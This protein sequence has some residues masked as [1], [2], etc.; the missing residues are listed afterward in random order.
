M[1]RHPRRIIERRDYAL[2][3]D[4]PV[5]V[6]TGDRWHIS[7]VRSP[8]LHFHNCIEIGLCHSDSGVLEFQDENLHFKAGDVTMI[9]GGIPHTTYSSQGESSRWSYIFF[10][11]SQILAASGYIPESDHFFQMLNNVR[12][13]T[14][15]EEDPH[16]APLVED[17]IYEMQNEHTHYKHCVRGLM[18]CL[19]CRL[20]RHLAGGV[21]EDRPSRSLPIAPALQYVADHYAENFRID[22][23]A[24]QCGM[25]VSYFRRVFTEIMGE[26]PL[27]YV[28][29]TRINRACTLLQH[30]DLNILQVCESVGFCSLSS[31][32]RH[33]LAMMGQPPT[34][35][36][37][38]AQVNKPQSLRAYSG[39]LVPPP[40]DAG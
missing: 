25:S 12:M 27:E 32:N 29:N 9:S 18:E 2:S 1:P 31:F 3:P 23:L 19:I 7:D 40:I 35:W 8:V 30:T 13:I 15:Q 38:N 34:V 24:R 37:K 21:A 36:R 10:D 39:W 33:F 16:L 6:L 14:S 22:A 4:F 11:L 20:S 26:G 17:I 5:L 28:N